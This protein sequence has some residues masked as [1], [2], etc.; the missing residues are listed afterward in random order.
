MNK[1]VKKAIVKATL[2]NFE[3]VAFAGATVIIAD[4]IWLLHDIVENGMN[5]WYLMIGGLMISGFL[6]TIAVIVRHNRHLSKKYAHDLLLTALDHSK[7]KAKSGG[8][9]K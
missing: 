7:R 3:L 2:T 6:S 4:M 8:K 5:V 9:R 1:L